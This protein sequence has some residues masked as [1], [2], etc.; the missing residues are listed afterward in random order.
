MKIENVNSRQNF[1][2]VKQGISMS[3]ELFSKIT[4]TQVV[5]TFAKKYDAELNLDMYQSSRI[6]S[7]E[8]FIALT[9]SEIKPANVLTRITDLFKKTVKGIVLKTYATNDADFVKSLNSKNK[10]S[11][12]DIYN[13]AS[14]R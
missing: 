9:V 4:K 10:Y 14:H 6:K 2:A 12:I 3:D 13:D 1:T 8:G 11:L 7:K 5:K